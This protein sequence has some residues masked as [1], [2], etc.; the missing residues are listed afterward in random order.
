[1]SAPILAD[2]CTMRALGSDVT[3]LESFGLDNGAVAVVIPGMGHLVV[4]AIQSR[5]PIVRLA[6]P[7][8]RAIFTQGPGKESTRDVLVLD[9]RLE[10]EL[11]P[12][13]AVREWHPPQ[14]R[15]ERLVV[16]IPLGDAS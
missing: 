15:E 4:G 5:E 2:G 10:V 1:M 11:L 8:Y 9:D 16:C 7:T 12:S 6:P 13:K 14:R 3:P